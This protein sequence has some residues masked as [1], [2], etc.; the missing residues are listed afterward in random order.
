[1]E[2][3][4]QL[5]SKSRSRQEGLHSTNSLHAGVA[6]VASC[7]RFLLYLLFL[8][9]EN[10]DVPVTLARFMLCRPSKHAGLL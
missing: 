10:Q 6:A 9:A 8:A 2:L 4:S 1:M 3:E 5:Y 7:S